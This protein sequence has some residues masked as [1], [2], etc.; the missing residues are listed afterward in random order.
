[1]LGGRGSQ[2]LVDGELGHAQ[3]L[4]S[5]SQLASG[6][7][8]ELNTPLAAAMGQLE[9]AMDARR[10]G[11]DPTERLRDAQEALDSIARVVA[12]LRKYSSGGQQQGACASLHESAEAALDLMA[13]DLRHRAEVKVELETGLEAGGDAGLWTDV[14]VGL[15]SRVSSAIEPGRA[16]QNEIQVVVRSVEGGTE[17]VIGHTSSASEDDPEA[18]VQ[19]R[20]VGG[21]RGELGVVLSEVLATNLQGTFEVDES[22]DGRFLHYRMWIPERGLS[23]QA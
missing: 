4:A 23:E 19:T 10:A 12:S 5:L 7:R 17:I 18:A 15:L 22:P 9:L 14:F 16:G 21:D 13:H 3:H 6:V 1:V 20:L 8:H 2:R 11:E